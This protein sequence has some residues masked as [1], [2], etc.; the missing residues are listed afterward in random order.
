MQCDVCQ[1]INIRGARYK[2][3]VC[4]DF[5]MCETCEAKV[6]HPHALLKIKCPAQAPL[7]IITVLDEEGASFFNRFQF[8]MANPFDLIRKF[9]PAHLFEKREEKE[10]LDRKDVQVDEKELLMSEEA[11][12]GFSCSFE[13]EAEPE[14]KPE[15]KPEL[16]LL[17]QKLK[18]VS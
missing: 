8:D 14:A 16:S 6:D 2:C 12:K 3:A 10:E 1:A 11:P 9:A 18:I 13:H 15:A 17:E 5:D 4:Q 7:K